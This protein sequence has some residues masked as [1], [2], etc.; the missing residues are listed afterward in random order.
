MRVGRRPTR[1][2]PSIPSDGRKS[3]NRDYPSKYQG[4][5]RIFSKLGYDS[6]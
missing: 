5:I 2:P 1:T 4:Y 6:R 3:P